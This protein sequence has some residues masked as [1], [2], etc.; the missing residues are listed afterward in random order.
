[1]NKVLKFPKEFASLFEEKLESLGFQKEEN[2]NVIFSYKGDNVKAVFY[3][4]G[5]LLLQGKGDLERI[6]KILTSNLPIEKNYI[7]T[8][9][10]GK[11]DLFGPLVV[12]GFALTED[13]TDKVLQL[14]VRDSKTL[15]Y[16]GLKIISEELLKL[17]RHKCLLLMPETYNKLYKAFQNL[18]KILSFAHANVIDALFMEHA[19]NKA[20]VDKFMKGSYID[21]Y[22]NTKIQIIEET[23]AERYPAVAAASILARYFYLK[24]LEELSKIAGIKLVAGSGIEAKKIF[25]ELKSKFEF[26]VLS[27]LAKLHFKV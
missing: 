1:M 26:K 27:K 3:P 4:T 14:G 13:I 17:N 18:N 7:G 9:E 21:C 15:T 10:A 2:P 11:G 20:V 19:L 8:D 16:E 6:V 12:C 24:K 25:Q 23:K 5:T 22:I